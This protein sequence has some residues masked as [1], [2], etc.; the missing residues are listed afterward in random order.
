MPSPPKVLPDPLINYPFFWKLSML[1]SPWFN[2][3]F[4]T[5]LFILCYLCHY[6]YLSLQW[7]FKY[8]E[9]ENFIIYLYLCAPNNV[10]TILGVQWMLGF[11]DFCNYV[12]VSFS[13]SLL[14]LCPCCFSLCLAYLLPSPTSF[15]PK[16]LVHASGPTQSPC[17]CSKAFLMITFPWPNNRKSL[18]SAFP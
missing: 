16:S 13:F 14:C 10:L 15:L 2:T 4:I 18:S 1:F 5:P 17:P 9:N 11:N 7:N 12:E 3:I 8:A 6:L